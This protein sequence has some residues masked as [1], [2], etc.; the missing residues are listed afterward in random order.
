MDVSVLLDPNLDLE[1]LAE[2]LDGLGHEGRVH[3]TRTWT[4]KRQAA[5]FEACQGRTLDLDYLVPPSVGPLVEVIHQGKNSLG[6]F[7]I[8]QKRFTRLP[9]GAG[10]EAAVAGCNYQT[11][12]RL[13]GP[14]YFV[15]RAQDGEIAI[16]YTKL[17]KHKPASWP[18]IRDNEGGLGRV[19]YG[20][21]VD[22]LRRVS[23]N[24]SIGRAWK[25]GKQMDA[26][27]VLVRK[28]PS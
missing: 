15:C 2:V 3:T 1:R 20:G 24:V 11:F 16:D 12:M 9:E 14:G 4:K 23:N 19:V 8:F 13:T 5:I 21:M 25:H 27:F 18:E 10:E 17:P 26:W 22:Y 7:S 28:D 6:A